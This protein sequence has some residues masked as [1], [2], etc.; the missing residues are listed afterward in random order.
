[1]SDVSEINAPYVIHNLHLSCTYLHFVLIAMSFV[2]ALFTFEC[3][4]EIKSG[5]LR[6]RDLRHT[7]IARTARD[8]TAIQACPGTSVGKI[9]LQKIVT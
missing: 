6:E 7:H 2:L 8:V 5:Q 3:H 9:Y 1:V 4:S